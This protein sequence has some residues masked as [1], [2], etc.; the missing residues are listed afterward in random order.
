[1]RLVQPKTLPEAI[2][3]LAT[4]PQACCLAGG[5]T[6]I[7][8]VKSG[9]VRPTQLVSL[10]RVEELHGLTVADNGS[11][12]IGA[13]TPHREVARAA[14]L[15]HGHEILREAAAQTAHPTIR[16]MATLGGSIAGGDPTADYPCALL[17]AGAD[18]L[19]ADAAGAFAVSVDDFFLDRYVTALAPG[20]IVTGAHLPATTAHET[21]AFVKFSRVDGDYATLTVG[22]RIGWSGEECR[23]LRIAIGSFGATP[24]RSPDVE[25]MLIGT[26]LLSAEVKRAGDAY[27]GLGRPRDD[28]KASANYR[29]LILPGMLQRA[30]EQARA[31]LPSRSGA[32]A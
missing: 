19:V 17:A 32:L 4:D 28:I 9:R 7:S 14:C 31:R 3:T 18:I 16:N 1:M 8:F 13:M 27:V 10:K 30:V 24:L 21:S 25:A 2:A 20:Q 12:V 6:L 11:V 26:R 15:L 23:S 29:R 5:A 22:V